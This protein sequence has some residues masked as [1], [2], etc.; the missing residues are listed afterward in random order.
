MV[1]GYFWGEN[2]GTFCPFDVKSEN[3]MVYLKLRE[4]LVLRIIQ[5]INDTIDDVVFQ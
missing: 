3:A 1:W 5:P 4:Y 2:R